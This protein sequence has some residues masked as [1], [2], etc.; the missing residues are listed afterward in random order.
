MG[1]PKKNSSQALVSLVK[2][3]YETEGNGDPSKLRYTLLASYA[4]SRGYDAESYD[5]RR[6][7]DVRAAIEEIRLGGETRTWQS[8]T[9][10]YRNIDVDAIFLRC[11]DIEELKRN[12]RG[13]DDYWR[14]IYEETVKTKREN[15]RLRHETNVQRQ[16]RELQQR[17]EELQSA[18]KASSREK[19]RLLKENAY[20]RRILRNS[21]YPALAEEL[22]RRENL[23]MP[24]NRTVKPEALD[25]LIEG[26]CPRAF[27]EERGADRR[28]ET[29]QERLLRQMREQVEKK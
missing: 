2:D 6:D 3:F 5:F 28:A 26:E 8:V 27:G 9:A 23:P 16:V 24:E 18:L 20:L 14:Q 10:A 22:L 11:S 7:A 25:A 17:A 21:L 4:K 15:E 29:R 12:I 1:R 13:M 19:G